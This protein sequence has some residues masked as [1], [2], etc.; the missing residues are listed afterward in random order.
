MGSTYIKSTTWWYFGNN[1]KITPKKGV[2]F[3]LRIRIEPGDDGKLKYAQLFKLQYQIL[4]KLTVVKD[5]YFT[6]KCSIIRIQKL[7]FLQV[8]MKRVE[9]FGKN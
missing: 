4:T 3:L 5:H 7:F 2:Q 1:L 8:I 9:D 6:K